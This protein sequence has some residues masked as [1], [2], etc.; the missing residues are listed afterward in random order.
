[1]NGTKVGTL[2]IIEGDFFK[3]GKIFRQSGEQK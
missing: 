3:K 2:F 1:M